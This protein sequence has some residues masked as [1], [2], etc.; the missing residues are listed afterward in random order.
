[1]T[2]KLGRIGSNRMTYYNLESRTIIWN[3]RTKTW[4]VR[5]IIQKSYKGTCTQNR[6]H[7]NMRMDC[8]PYWIIV[9]KVKAQFS[10]MEI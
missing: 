4:E 3:F 8:R 1:M 5:E 10:G 6:Q 2:D 7:T 9:E